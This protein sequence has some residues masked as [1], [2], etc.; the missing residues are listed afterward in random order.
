MFW[1]GSGS[2]SSESE[3]ER[4]QAGF[5]L[6]VTQP[7]VS[8]ARLVRRRG[9]EP[10]LYIISRVGS[11]TSK[12]DDLGILD[13]RGEAA[14]HLISAPLPHSVCSGMSGDRTLT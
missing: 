7:A 2:L 1:S 12:L 10:F 4:K 9:V 13:S 8:T 3:A 14:G 6:A 5:G 11:E